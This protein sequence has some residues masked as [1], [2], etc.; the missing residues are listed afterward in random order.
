VP[1]ADEGGKKLSL[2]NLYVPMIIIDSHMLFPDLAAQRRAITIK[3]MPS[4]EKVGLV[5]IEKYL[6]E[7]D[8]KRKY[9]Y[10][11]YLK[12][13]ND[14][15]KEVQQVFG[16]FNKHKCPGDLLQVFSLLIAVAR[17]IDSELGTNEYTAAVYRKA[18]EWLKEVRSLAETADPMKQL[19][20][21]IREL[22]ESLAQRLESGGNNGKNGNSP[23]KLW[24]QWKKGG[25]A[26]QFTK[27]RRYIA[28]QFKE[29]ERIDLTRRVEKKS[30]K[31]VTHEWPRYRLNEEI[32]KLTSRERFSNIMI[33]YLKGF[34]DVDH[35][36]EHYL[37]IKDIDTARRALE[38]LNKALYMSAHDSCLQALGYPATAEAQQS[39]GGETA[40]VNETAKPQEAS[41][42]PVGDRLNEVLAETIAEIKAKLKQQ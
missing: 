29:L 3:I 39:T 9:L 37:V 34:I 28:S 18:A 40:A 25:Y 10:A 8:S 33:R 41:G 7:G 5:D 22:I 13:A 12:Y 42:G 23:P 26:I 21:K 14:V 1:R 20:S 16:D 38:E 32:E 19:L 36:R 31:E 27:L 11:A 24:R 4:G 17:I 35:R 30:K 6:R 2:Y 15:Y